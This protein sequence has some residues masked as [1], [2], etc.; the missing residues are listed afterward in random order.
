MNLTE[1]EQL[2]KEFEKYPSPV[3]ETTF[4]DICRYPRS[5]FEEICSRILAFYIQ[6]SN[7]HGLKD[8]VLSSFFELIQEEIQFNFYNEQIIVE[9]EVYIEEKSLDLLVKGNFFALG[10][11]NKINSEVY[12]PLDIYKNLIENTHKNNYKIVLSLRK[13]EKKNEL[14]KIKRNDFII[15]YYNDLFR[16][17]KNN[18]GNYF[19]NANSKYV[20]FLF[21]FINTLEAMT[22]NTIIDDPQSLFFFENSKAID[23]LIIQYNNHKNKILEI[24]KNN[25]AILHDEI[26]RKT[27]VNWWVWQGWDLGYN[28][29]VN[30]KHKIG[31]ESKYELYDRDPL[32]VFKIYI[33]TWNLKDWGYYETDVL[34]KYSRD[35][36]YLDTKTSNRAYL[37]V[38]KIEDD[39][40]ELIL[41]KLYEHYI[42]LKKLVETK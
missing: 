23:E 31:I 40:T 41:E 7:E 37:H 15:V 1:F 2:I 42:F 12:N 17:I 27:G 30:Q 9:T 24:Q 26:S 36:Y 38:D 3:Y 11:E 14:E 13:I 19:S 16:V 32:K 10:I 8:L 28:S 29:F 18:L 35:N 25:I 34:K 20:T 4:L 21:D 39:N 6:P 22:K 33:T 5:R